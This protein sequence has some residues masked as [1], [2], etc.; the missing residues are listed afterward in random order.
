MTFDSAANAKTWD[1]TFNAGDIKKLA[2]LYAKN[3]RALPAGGAP[4]SGGDAIAKFFEGVRANGLTKHHVEVHEVVE[5]GD[6]AISTG[7]WNL[8]GRGPDGQNQRFGGNWTQVAG[9][10]GDSWKILLH[11]WN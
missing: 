8:T 6:T 11:T 2:T 9:K 1:D 3:A 4:V 7:T 5:R 10:E